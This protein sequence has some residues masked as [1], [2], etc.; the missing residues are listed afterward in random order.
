MAEMTDLLEL[1]VHRLDTLIEEVRTL[2]KELDSTK[3]RSFAKEVTESLSRIEKEL[4]WVE[5]ATF[6]EQVTDH[7]SSI[8]QAIGNLER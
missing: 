7:L 8:E 5:S 3:Y 6:A 1:V 4:S 2:N